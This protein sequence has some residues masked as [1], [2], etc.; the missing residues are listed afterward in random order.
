MKLYDYTPAPN[1]RRVRIFI[2]EKGLD[3]PTVQVDLR[4]KEQLTPAFQ[5]INPFCDVPVLELDDGTFISQV[6]GI[7]RYLE[8]AF[9][10]PDLY[11]ANAKEQGQIAMWDHYAFTHGIT[12]VAD[13]FR[14]S[15]EGFKDR[16]VLGARGYAQISELAQRGKDRTLD[17]FANMNN[18]L[19]D[20]E[21]I[22]GDRF[23]AADI[24]TL[25]TIDFAKWIKA[26]VDESQ[27]H[28]QRWY[29]AVSAR[30][31]ASA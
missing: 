7:C 31:S 25:I 19:A 28:L 3:V 15:A 13:A 10:T 16:A 14:N 22:A 23:S 17:F 5:K 18:F 26:E 29:T 9:P 2:A 12:A 1:P 20:R 8:A 27:T 21:F 4:N 24:T 11:G 30:P 6:N